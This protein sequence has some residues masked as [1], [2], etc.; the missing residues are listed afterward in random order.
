MRLRISTFTARKPLVQS[1]TPSRKSRLATT[2]PVWEKMLRCQGTPSMRPPGDEARGFDDV[3]AALH[4]SYEFRNIG[5][6]I[7]ILPHEEGVVEAL[8]RGLLDA[9]AQGRSVAGVL[10]VMDYGEVGEL[11]SQAVEDGS[12]LVAAA[13]VHGDELAGI[14]DP[15]SAGQTRRTQISAPLSSL[16]IGM[17][18]Q[19][20]FFSSPGSEWPEGHEKR[21]PVLPGLAFGYL[22]CSAERVS[23]KSSSASTPATVDIWQVAERCNL[24]GQ[25][26]IV[27]R[28]LSTLTN[29]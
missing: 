9:G 3:D 20:V 5:R 29:P 6:V 18:T 24:V 16:Y 26:W 10:L 23:R 19:K 25:A 22:P 15:A 12:R 4:Q 1:R 2:F 17:M 21:W 28:G 8:L 27:F 11:G 13:V 14:R 7:V